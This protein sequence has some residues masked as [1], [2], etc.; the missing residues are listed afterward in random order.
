MNLFDRFA[1]A[2]LPLVP[3]FIVRRLSTR[4]IAGEQMADALAM[5]KRMQQA[6]YRVTYDILGEAVDHREG[7][8]AAAEEYQQLLAALVENQLELNI[9]LKPTQMGLNISEDFCVEV[10]SSILKEAQKHGAFVRYEMEDSPTTDGTLRVFTRLRQEFG[11]TVGC[12]LQ[13]MLHRTVQDC[14]D[15]VAVDQPLNVRMV[16]GIYVEPGAI[17]HQDPQQVNQA[18]LDATQV[19]LEGGA[20][21]ALATH[22]PAL[23]DGARKIVKEIPGSEDRVEVQMLLGVQETQRKE[24]KNSGLPVR[25]YIPYGTQ[26]YPYVT[27]RLKKNPKLARYAMFGLFKKKERLEP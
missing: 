18:Y 25:V 17:A 20:Y 13:S 1:A 16:K 3:R 21:V 11:E 12:V 5:G 26:W 19:L 15:L 6:G 27:R 4:Y 7:V 9:S 10:V 23:V 8:L 22:D 2:C 24:W 14:K